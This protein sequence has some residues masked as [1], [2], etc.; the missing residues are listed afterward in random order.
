VV[1]GDVLARVRI[2][3]KRPIFAA[4]LVCHFSR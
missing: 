1:P 2:Y 4:M 3:Y